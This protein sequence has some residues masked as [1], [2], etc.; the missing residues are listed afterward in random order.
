MT[1]VLEVTWIVKN[2]NPNP[3]KIHPTR[4]SLN[5]D[6]NLNQIQIQI[7][8]NKNKNYLN[9]MSYSDDIKKH[10]NF[11]GSSGFFTV[12]QFYFLWIRTQNTGS[13]SFF[14]VRFP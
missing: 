4:N 7:E 6:P 14:H 12:F 3:T 11:L 2:L 8:N 9:L 10:E 5:R 13:V 1:Y